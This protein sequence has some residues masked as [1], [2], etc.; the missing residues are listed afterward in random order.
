MNKRTTEE[1]REQVI[2]RQHLMETI[3]GSVALCLLF[4]AVAMYYINFYL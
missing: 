2:K 3:I 1:L 4:T